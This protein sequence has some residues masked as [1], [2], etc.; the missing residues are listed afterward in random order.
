VPDAVDDGA[1]PVQLVATNATASATTARAALT[2]SL[3]RSLGGLL[4]EPAQHGPG[5]GLEAALVIGPEVA[6][7]AGV[8]V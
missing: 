1:L 7:V 6:G 4:I 5:V 2:R 3:S 8:A